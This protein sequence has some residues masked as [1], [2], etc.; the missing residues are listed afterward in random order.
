MRR[1]APCSW[2]AGWRCGTCNDAK[3]ALAHF[4]AFTKSADGPLSQARAHYW[5]G[6]TYEALGDQAKAR[7]SYRTAAASTSTPST[8]S[9]RA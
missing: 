1:T 5:L 7:E 3:D 6:R 8:A 4:E 9:S 2:P